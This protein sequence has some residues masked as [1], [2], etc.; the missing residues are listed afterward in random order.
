[1]RLT[2]TSA[3][4]CASI[5]LVALA[6][7]AAAPPA[8]AEEVAVTD[9]GT[10]TR[11][12]LAE[13]PPKGGVAVANGPDG[14]V[15]I[16][17]VRFSAGASAEAVRLQLHEAQG[18]APLGASLQACTT[19]ADWK[20]A[21]NGRMSDA[22]KA[23][24]GAG[25]APLASHG[26]GTWSGDI[27]TLLGLSRSIVLLPGAGAAALFS[28]TFDRPTVVTTTGAATDT[29]SAATPAA[30]T[31]TV[32]APNPFEGAPAPAPFSATPSELASPIF[33]PPAAPPATGAAATPRAAPPAAAAAANLRAPGRRTGAGSNRDLA[34]A[35]RLVL[36]AAAIGAASVP[37]WRIRDGEHVPGLS[38]LIDAWRQRATGAES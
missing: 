33:T 29:T 23:D 37:I 13:A 17:A 36:L 16:A 20:P 11:N 8:R 12:P 38:P 4:R 24:C 21:T 14:P 25:A 15:T 27:S 3:I 28:L 19:S 18:M 35:V 6:L 1:M 26:D 2:G 30:E 5:A 22:P 31:E 9:V 34:Q 10:W 32:A 7:M